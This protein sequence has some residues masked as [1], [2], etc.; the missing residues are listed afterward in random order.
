M[1]NNMTIFNKTERFLLFVGDIL[2][3]SLSLWLSLL[4]RDG[5][6]PDLFMFLSHFVPFSIIFIAWIIVFYI[7]GLYDKYTTILKEK[8]PLR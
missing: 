1:A 4:I 7:S 6:L 8:I 5:N 2:I 3:F